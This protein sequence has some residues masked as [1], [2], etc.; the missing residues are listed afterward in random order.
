VSDKGYVVEYRMWP[1][2]GW[3][4]FWWTAS[5]AKANAIENYDLNN[6]KGA[7]RRAR[8][9]KLARCAHCKVVEAKRG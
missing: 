7:Y 4:T 2:G 8:D 1:S 3:M 9:K 5:H 6:E